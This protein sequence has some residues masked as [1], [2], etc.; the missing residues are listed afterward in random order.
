LTPL[1]YWASSVSPLMSKTR[2]SRPLISRTRVVSLPRRFC[3]RGTHSSYSLSLSL[4]YLLRSS[5]FLSSFPSLTPTPPPRPRRRPAGLAAGASRGGADGVVRLGG[6]T[7]EMVL[8]VLHCGQA[9][10][11]DRVVELSRRGGRSSRSRGRSG[12]RIRSGLLRPLPAGVLTIAVRGLP[13]GV[14][15]EAGGGER[16]GRRRRCEAGRPPARRRDPPSEWH[17]RGREQGCG[18]STSAGGGSEPARAQPPER[19]GEGCSAV[20]ANGGGA[21]RLHR[22]TRE[23]VPV[24]PEEGAARRGAAAANVWR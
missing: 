5:L 11:R 2:Y 13:P 12:G 24:W 9:G 20:G 14:G 16:V 6:S 15:D 7:T 21:L 1:K 18:C 23:G 17:H 4:F 8:L 3:W 10:G 19:M 22:R